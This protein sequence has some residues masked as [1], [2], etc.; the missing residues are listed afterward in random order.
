MRSFFQDVLPTPLGVAI[1]IAVLIASFGAP[2]AP[3]M[4]FSV[5]GG[6]LGPPTLMTA[7]LRDNAFPAS[8]G[9]TRA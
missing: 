6:G 9:G 2:L 5:F 7:G 3:G 4:I 1:A 8:I